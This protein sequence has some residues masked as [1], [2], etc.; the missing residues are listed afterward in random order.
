MPRTAHLRD[1]IRIAA[2]GLA[3]NWLACYQKNFKHDCFF[4]KPKMTN[5]QK[6]VENPGVWYRKNW[7][8]FDRPKFSKFCQFWPSDTRARAGWRKC[9]IGEN[10][11]LRKI[12]EFFWKSSPR[13]TCFAEPTNLLWITKIGQIFDLPK[14]LTRKN[15]WPMKHTQTPKRVPLACAQIFGQ[16]FPILTQTKIDI[17][18]EFL[19]IEY[20]LWG[21]N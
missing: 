2:H 3:T 15:F 1:Q 20:W 14:F 8:I 21:E 19:K 5:F 11:W 7:K 13:P 4:T 6:C 16:I 10:F 17:K 9:L 18:N 12:F